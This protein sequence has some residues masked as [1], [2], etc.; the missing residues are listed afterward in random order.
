M[1]DVRNEGFFVTLSFDF[2]LFVCL[3]RGEMT[4][5][6]V[7]TKEELEQEVSPEEVDEQDACVGQEIKELNSPFGNF[8]KNLLCGGGRERK[9]RVESGEID[10]NDDPTVQVIYFKGVLIKF[11]FSKKATKIEKKSSPSIWHLLKVS[12]LGCVKSLVSRYIEG[13]SFLSI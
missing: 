13:C 3:Q 8:L 11:V 6:S 2:D 10:V 5:F 7:L 1:L 12:S 9:A 4:S